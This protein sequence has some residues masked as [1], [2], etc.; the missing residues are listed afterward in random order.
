M[1]TSKK[2]GIF[3]VSFNH[4]FPL[5]KI[6]KWLTSMYFPWPSYQE[7]FT[8]T[9]LGLLIKNILLLLSLA[10]R[11]Q[12][13]YYFSLHRFIIAFLWPTFQNHMSIYKT[14]ERERERETHQ[15][16]D[17]LDKILVWYQPSELL[18]Q[19]YILYKLQHLPK[20]TN[21]LGLPRPCSLIK[22][23]KFQIYFLE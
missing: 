5:S 17:S 21:Q 9:F 3:L 7:D 23:L 2:F 8:I 22:S 16:L 18:M 10:K 11:P 4:Y 14:F 1:Q 15:C 20:L 6:C 13:Y 19:K 12:I